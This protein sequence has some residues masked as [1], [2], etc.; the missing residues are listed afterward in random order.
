[1]LIMRTASNTSYFTNAFDQ[2]KRSRQIEATVHYGVYQG[3]TMIGDVTAKSGVVCTIVTRT[4]HC[5]DYHRYESAD[6]SGASQLQAAWTDDGGS[7]E[8]FNTTITFGTKPPAG[9]TGQLRIS[10]SRVSL[11]GP[12]ASVR[13]HCA[14]ANGTRCIGSLAVR[15]AGSQLGWQG[16][17][18]RA[19]RTAVVYVPISVAA[20][21]QIAR[22][23]RKGVVVAR[24]DRGRTATRAVVLG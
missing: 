16:Y 24:P 5:S 15:S 8:N 19:N 18:V 13:V 9:R 14:S 7:P 22:R 10:S 20:A 6:T 2:R 1:V 17:S 4:G 12:L 3:N 21:N 11:T 23:P